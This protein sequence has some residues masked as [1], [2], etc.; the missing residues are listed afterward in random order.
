MTTNLINKHDAAKY[1]KTERGV[2][3]TTPNG[4]AFWT[5]FGT[6]R[7]CIDCGAIVAGGPTRCGRCAKEATPAM[8]AL[9]GK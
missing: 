3:H 1:L 7:A 8:G 4:D 5:P 6:V 2:A 9:E